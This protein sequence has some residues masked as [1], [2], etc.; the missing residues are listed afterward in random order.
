MGEKI[1]VKPKA[2]EVDFQI[3]LGDTLEY[4]FSWLDSEKVAIPLSGYTALL[5]LKTVKTSTSSVAE[6]TH[7]TGIT[8]TDAKPNI[9]ISIDESVI[10]A[11]PV[12]TPHFYDLELTSA[13]GVV[14]T[15]ITGVITAVQ[16]TSR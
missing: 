13:G 15:I 14:T 7:L 3:F 4:A 1:V 6:I 5:Q 11:L 2:A 16:D 12:N 10:I 9:S 8:L